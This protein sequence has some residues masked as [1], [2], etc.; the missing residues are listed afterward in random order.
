V[1]G[2]QGAV[3]GAKDAAAKLGT[4][5]TR[6]TAALRG[7]PADGESAAYDSLRSLDEALSGLAALLREVPRIVELGDPAPAVRKRLERSQQELA[8]RRADIAAYRVALEGLAETEK[9]L[10]ETSAQ[11]SALRDQVAMLEAAKRTAAEIPGL[12][13]MV[14]ALEEDL[15]ALDASGGVDV[16]ARLT[17]ATQRLAALTDN[18]RASASE[19]AASLA[20]K[21]KAAVGELTELR[22]R[23]ATAAAD[24][25]RHE[26][27]AEQLRAEHSDTLPV[28]AAWSQ[29]DL[30]LASGL[31]TALLSTADT[32]LEAVHA[33]LT[34]IRQRLEQ[35][36]ELLGPLLAEQ[37]RAYEQ[38]RQVRSL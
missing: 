22:D 31:R 35:L 25:A 9:D 24:L 11:A 36:D 23:V 21:V 16:I 12:R 4:A 29:A 33:E 28:L 10:G 1:S 32:P 5:V 34:G 3:P 15:A 38:A 8:E 6:V 19:E 14:Q 20:V 18:Q 27:D 7:I 17:A 26:S 37:T 30:N 2:G 13:A